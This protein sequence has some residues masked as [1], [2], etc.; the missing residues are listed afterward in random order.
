MLGPALTRAWGLCFP[1]TA[2][3]VRV[4]RRGR[5]GSF[6]RGQALRGAWTSPVGQQVD[7]CLLELNRELLPPAGDGDF[8]SGGEA[9]EAGRVGLDRLRRVLLSACS[10]PSGERVA[11]D[12]GVVEGRSRQRG[13]R[14]LR[15]ERLQLALIPRG[16]ENRARPPR[17][18]SGPRA[19]QARV[20]VR[21]RREPFRGLSQRSRAKRVENRVRDLGDRRRSLARGSSRVLAWPSGLPSWSCA[22]KVCDSLSVSTRSA[23]GATAWYPSFARHVMVSRAERKLWKRASSSL[24][25]T[26]PNAFCHA[27]SSE[28]CPA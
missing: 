1:A 10:P 8:C 4:V 6:H 22:S 18:R 14:Y 21:D 20:L 15:G 16:V 7:R 28:R 26:S 11:R 3:G 5:T 13:R 9:R 12:E 2:R 17:S 19:A 25:D 23:S 27:C 24:S